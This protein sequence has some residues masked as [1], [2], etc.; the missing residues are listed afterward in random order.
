MQSNRVQEERA[1]MRGL[2]GLLGVGLIA[3]F[4]AMAPGEAAAV[5]I[6]QLDCTIAGT[7]CTAS[8][9]F[10]TLTFTDNGATVTVDVNLTGTENKILAVIL[11]YDDGTSP[12]GTGLSVTGSATTLTFSP[13]NVDADGC[14]NC[15]DIAVPATGNVGTTDTAT[16]IFSNSNGAL[17]I[18]DFFLTNS[19]GLDAAV[20]IG[21][22]GPDTGV[23]TPGQTGE[24][25]VWAGETGNGTAVPEPATLLLLGSGL[26]GVTYLGRRWGRRP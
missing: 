22:C 17:D 7:T 9:S 5:E 14:T 16:L 10:G 18:T 4:T 20:H 23:C 24:N 19:V 8:D 21:N 12:D 25:S 1:M 2:W 13:D 6:S 3:L 11:N 26:V 15:F